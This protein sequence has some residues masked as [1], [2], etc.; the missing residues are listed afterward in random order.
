MARILLIDDDPQALELV[1]AILGAYE[2]DVISHGS[3]E[4]G[5]AAALGD[6]APDLLITD[7]NM[8][9]M[10]GWEVV[11]RIRAVRSEAELPILALSA[12]TSAKDRDEA[13]EAGCNAYEN[14][15]VDI[16]HLTQRVASLLA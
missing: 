13:F 12:F 16:E 1:S 15:P 10:S 11:R 8:R 14:K 7:L 3:G 5:V 4:A 9:G 6:S 2:H